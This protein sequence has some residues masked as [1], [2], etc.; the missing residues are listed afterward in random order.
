[1]RRFQ[2][3]GILG[4]QAARRTAQPTTFTPDIRAAIIRHARS[5]P[6]QFGLDR[7]YWSLRSLQGSLVRH[8]IVGKISVQ[9]LR[10]ILAEADVSF[11]EEARPSEPQSTAPLRA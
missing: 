10:R 8:R 6:S 5:T 4:L 11:R 3:H 7:P 1:L 2:R 9:H